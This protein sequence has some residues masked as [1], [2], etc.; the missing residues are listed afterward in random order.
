ML[1]ILTKPPKLQSKITI[2]CGGNILIWPDNQ[3]YLILTSS[4]LPLVEML[5]FVEYQ[6]QLYCTVSSVQKICRNTPAKPSK[7][8]RQTLKFFV[9][10]NGSDGMSKLAL[11]TMHRAYA[12]RPSKPFQ[13]MPKMPNPHL[14]RPATG[15]LGTHRTRRPNSTCQR[16]PVRQRRL[17]CLAG[18]IDIGESAEDAVHREVMEE[19]G[20]EIDNIRYFGSQSWPFPGGSF[21]IGFIARYKQG[22]LKIDQNELEDAKWFYKNQLPKLPSPLSL[23]CQI[24]KA[25]QTL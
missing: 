19:T 4:L 10:T 7:I 2:F 3:D 22:T 1:N 15:Y 24:I 25:Y 20:L 12:K 14:A 8:I 13:N 9:Y 5:T 11:L 21:M 16:P 6:D 17:C 18:F 23:S